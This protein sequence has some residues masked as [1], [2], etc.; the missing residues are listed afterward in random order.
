MISDNVSANAIA[1]KMNGIELED[2]KE[3][4]LPTMQIPE[5]IKAEESMLPPYL[6]F[7]DSWSRRVI[8]LFL[9]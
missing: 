2:Y 1:K 7:T 6:K 5:S 9:I 8:S 3:N 4:P